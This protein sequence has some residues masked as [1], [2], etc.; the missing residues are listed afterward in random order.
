MRFEKIEERATQLRESVDAIKDT[1]PNPIERKAEKD[2]LWKIHKDTTAIRTKLEVVNQRADDALE[3]SYE[4]KRELEAEKKRTD[5][6]FDK[7][8]K[9]RR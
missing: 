4:V 8:K 3:T 1:L 9:S 7:L 5:R 2:I 6:M